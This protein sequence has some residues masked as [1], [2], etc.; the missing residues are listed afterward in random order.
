MKMLADLWNCQPGENPIG[1]ST[2]VSSEGCM[3]RGWRRFIAGAPSAK[4][5]QTH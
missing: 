4:L 2:I 3:L 5:K 1:T